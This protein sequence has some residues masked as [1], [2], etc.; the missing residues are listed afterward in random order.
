MSFVIFPNTAVIVLCFF[1]N[2]FFLEK[3]LF[4]SKMAIVLKTKE[5]TPKNFVMIVVL[6]S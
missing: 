6:K 2:V 3:S 1:R 4:T 5:Q